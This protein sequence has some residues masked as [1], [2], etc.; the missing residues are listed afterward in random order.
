MDTSATVEVEWTTSPIMVTDKK[1]K[2]PAQAGGVVPKAFLKYVGVSVS[3]P[4][5]NYV[6]YRSNFHIILVL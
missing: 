5:L 6:T 1:E 4:N 2:Q 3:S